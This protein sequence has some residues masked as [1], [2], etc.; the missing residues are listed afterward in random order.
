MATDETFDLFHKYNR[1][2]RRRLTKPL[3]CEACGHN[4][5]TSLGSDD[6]LILVCYVCPYEVKPGTRLI[7]QVRAV[8]KEHFV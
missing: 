1:L 2:V 6:S 3:A 7:E 8:V 4:L 5:T